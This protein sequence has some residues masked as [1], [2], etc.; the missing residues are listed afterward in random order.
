M[1]QPFLHILQQQYAV[2]LRD[3]KNVEWMRCVWMCA[4]GRVRVR[5]H[6]LLVTFQTHQLWP[7]SMATHLPLELR[8]SWRGRADGR[9]HWEPSAET[10]AESDAVCVRACVTWDVK[11]LSS[12]SCETWICFVVYTVTLVHLLCGVV[13]RRAFSRSRRVSQQERL[14][15]F[16]FHGDGSEWYVLFQTDWWGTHGRFDSSPLLCCLSRSLFRQRAAVADS[17]YGPTCH[18][19]AENQQKRKE[20]SVE[21]LSGLQPR[22]HFH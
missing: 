21:M 18:Q 5:L 15:Q 17:A 20:E 2:S 14:I 16:S 4:R 7:V 10:E 11:N 22:W 19:T 6:L 13:Y 1:H 9:E 8:Q 3:L 12:P